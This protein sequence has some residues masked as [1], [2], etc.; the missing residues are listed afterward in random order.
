MKNPSELKT[1]ILGT[2]FSFFFLFK[3]Y[4]LDCVWRRYIDSRL[5]I[6]SRLTAAFSFLKLVAV[7]N[8]VVKFAV[9]GLLNGFYFF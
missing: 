8:A 6:S 9:D 1:R 3:K 2:L 4:S 5:N 7:C